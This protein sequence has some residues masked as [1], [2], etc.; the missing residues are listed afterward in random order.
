MDAKTDTAERRRDG[1]PRAG[2]D[3]GAAQARRA[4][5]EGQAHRQGNHRGD[6]GGGTVPRAA[7]EALGRLRAADRHLLRCR[8]GAGRRR[9]VGRLGLRRGRHAS[10]GAVAVRR[11]RR[12]RRLGQGSLDADLVVADAVRR[13]EAGA[14]RPPG[15]RAAG[16]IR[17]AASTATGRFSAR[18]SKATAQ[19]AIRT[20]VSSSCRARTTRSSTP[21]TSRASRAPAATTSR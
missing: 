21:G 17:A 1:R 4:R 14:R 15:L 9:H 16:A 2:D 13:C 20:A 12:E 3:P 11:S 6:A 18:R 8:D 7:A 5:R 19:A 10:V